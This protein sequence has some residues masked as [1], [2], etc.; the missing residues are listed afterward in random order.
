MRHMDAGYASIPVPGASAGHGGTSHG[1]TSARDT[2]FL[3]ATNSN[4]TDFDRVPS[5]G[6][7]NGPTSPGVF[8]NGGQADR[9][10]SL[11]RQTSNLNSHGGGFQ[12]YSSSRRES[13]SSN[14]TG[15]HV[16][17]PGTA[18]EPPTPPLNSNI[19][20]IMDRDHSPG[21]G[22]GMRGREGGRD[23]REG[24]QHGGSRRTSPARRTSPTRRTSPLS[25]ETRTAGVSKHSV[26]ALHESVA[27]MRTLM[28]VQSRQ[29]KEQ[30]LMLKALMGHLQ[31]PNNHDSEPPKSP[32]RS[33][34]RSESILR[35][36]SLEEME[37]LAAAAALALETEG[38][39]AAAAVISAAGNVV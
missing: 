29:I 23:E 17:L 3:E 6:N 31:R 33:M 26:E 28:E 36:Q 27:A 1:G 14:R 13:M 8:A 19:R 35:E 5:R 7:G 10:R 37:G 30:G 24:S 18:D 12:G 2:R 15:E 38:P 34:R 25:D 22:V 9:F 20:K 16:A 32:N 4:G 21:T 11:G 39:E